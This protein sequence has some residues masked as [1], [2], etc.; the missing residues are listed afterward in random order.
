MRAQVTGHRIE[1]GGKG[2]RAMAVQPV[3]A[4][5]GSAGRP[6]AGPTRNARRGADGRPAVARRRA[7][8]RAPS[9][10][11]ATWW[12]AL[13][14][15]AALLAFGLATHRLP[16]WLVTA[17][18]VLNLA[19]FIAYWIDK[20][21]AEAGRQRT[22]ENTLHLFALLGGWPAAR[23]AQQRLRHK[24]SKAE[25]LRVYTATVVAH[26]ALLAAWVTGWLDRF[27]R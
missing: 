21:A 1:V 17:L 27:V 6:A 18:A 8:S 10:L 13:L 9:S 15:G 14:V 7:G 20:R 23:V 16:A 25:F 19:T 2:P 3:G 22:P 24:S 4:A 26:L 11:G 12:V 5:A